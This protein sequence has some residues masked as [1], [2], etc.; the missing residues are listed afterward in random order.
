V[1]DATD[2]MEPWDVSWLEQAICCPWSSER[3][4]R[5]YCMGHANCMT[6]RCLEVCPEH[7]AECWTQDGVCPGE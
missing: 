3:H 6:A 5:G 1:K 2:S 7:Y 4:P